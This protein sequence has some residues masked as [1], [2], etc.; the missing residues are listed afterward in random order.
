MALRNKAEIAFYLC[1]VLFTTHILQVY[2]YRRTF[3]MKEECKLFQN[4]PLDEY[5]PFYNSYPCWIPDSWQDRIVLL[6]SNQYWT[7]SNPELIPAGLY[8]VVE[9][10]L[11]E[12]IEY[13][14]IEADSLFA[15][16]LVKWGTGAREMKKS[17]KIVV[18]SA[19]VDCTPCWGAFQEWD[20]VADA[21]GCIADYYYNTDEATCERCAAGTFKTVSRSG[22]CMEGD[23]TRLTFMIKGECTSDP[24]FVPCLSS[25][26]ERLTLDQELSGY[27]QAVVRRDW[28][29]NS[30]TNL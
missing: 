13:Q 9:L 24:E 7:W 28:M 20:P 2:A 14:Q 11:N 19:D 26:N 4:G 15:G 16:Y 25:D 22:S 23:A 27:F 18:C 21:C 17:D 8:N 1:F 3:V 12:N 10:R 29:N 6:Y 30:E 5:R